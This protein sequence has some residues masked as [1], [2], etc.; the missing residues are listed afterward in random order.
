MPTWPT[1]KPDSTAFDNADDAISTSRAEIKTM[2]DAV[3]DIVD[4]VDP[5]GITDGQFLA[6]DSAS[7]K[8]LPQTIVTTDTDTHVDVSDGLTTVN[9]ASILRFAGSEFTVALAGSDEANVGLRN[10]Y[11]IIR[12]QCTSGGSYTLN[13]VGGGDNQGKGPGETRLYATQNGG[14]TGWTVNIQINGST[15]H[16]TSSSSIFVLV[17][18]HRT[19]GFR[20]SGAL[21][22]TLVLHHIYEV[23]A[24]NTVTETV[25]MGTFYS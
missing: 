3:N 15:V 20:L 10:T 1:N 6:Y 21:I 22:E 7:Q 9:D 24:S 13:P 17:R 25:K 4:Y 14:S 12:V 19:G 23:D 11:D 16:T 2:S 18:T 8:L 5:T